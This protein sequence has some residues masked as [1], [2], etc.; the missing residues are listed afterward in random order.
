MDSRHSSQ[1]RTILDA[2]ESSGAEQVRQ[3]LRAMEIYRRM[4]QVLIGAPLAGHDSA[5]E[6]NPDPGIQ[7][8]QGP[9]KLRTRLAAFNDD[10]PAS[11]LQ[12]PEYFRQVPVAARITVG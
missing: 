11:R 8:D 7:V 3:L 6:G 5:D 12:H 1:E 4:G 10:E 2:A 9:E